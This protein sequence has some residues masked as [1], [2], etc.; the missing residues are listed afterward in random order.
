MSLSKMSEVIGII[1][2]TVIILHI[3]T[4]LNIIISSTVITA[5][6]GRDV[7]D[8]VRY[9]LL[10]VNE[11]NYC[12]IAVAFVPWHGASAL[13]RETRMLRMTRALPAVSRSGLRDYKGCRV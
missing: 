3:I 9:I 10:Y 1:I 5:A 2:T 11:F 12:C 6:H 8:G 4:I 13:P 7:I